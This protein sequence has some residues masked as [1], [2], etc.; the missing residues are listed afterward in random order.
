MSDSHR[1]LGKFLKQARESLDPEQ[2][3]LLP[4]GRIR[5]VPGLR[6]EEVALLAGVSTDYYARLEQGRNLSPSSQVIDA[7]INA[8]KLDSA[9]QSYLRALVAPMPRSRTRPKVQRVRPGLHQLL[10][11]FTL[12]PALILGHRTDILASNALARALFA[13]FEEMPAK[14]RNYVRWMLL[15]EDARALFRDWEEQA[16]NAV[17]ALRLDA[18]MMSDDRS[19]QELIGELSLASADFRSWWS[20]RQVHQRTYGTKRLRHPLVGDLDVQFEAFGLSEDSSQVLYIYT[21]EPGTTSQDALNM[22]ASWAQSIP[23]AAQ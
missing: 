23:A 20:G 7:L 21:A 1:E 13:D 22:L 9:G 12:Q 8:L 14:H 5:R 2:T 3:G 11:S 10:D 16:R 6:R 19:L 17:E 18:A 4:D 15:D